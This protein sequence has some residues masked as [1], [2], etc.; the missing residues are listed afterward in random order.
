V[1]DRPLSLLLLQPP[2]A[3]ARKA[4]PQRPQLLFNV[5]ARSADHATEIL[6]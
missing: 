2:L 6:L 4:L 5:L 1:S 3:S